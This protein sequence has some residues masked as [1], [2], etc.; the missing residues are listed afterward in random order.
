MIPI[1]NSNAI[2]KMR[3]VNAL[4]AQTQKLISQHIKVGITTK[5]LDA[6]AERFILEQG[7]KPNF[8]GYGNFPN[9]TCISVNDTVIHGVP[10]DYKLKDGDIVSVD[11]GAELDGFHGDMA[12]T[13]AVGQITEEARRLIEVTKE[14]FYKA[15]EQ[16]KEGS[17]V[18]D[19]SH[20]VQTHAE[21]HGYSVVKTYTGHG[22]GKKLHEDPSIPNFGNLSTG[23]KL[24]AGMTLAIEPMVNLGK[25]EVKVD[26]DGFSVK[27][28]DGKI[29]AHYENTVLVTKGE[30]EILSR[31]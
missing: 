12:R 13:Y 17:R 10:S 23:T 9:T 8:K 14:C 5:E 15:L 31:C 25:S 20:A 4:V 24:K 2:E 3:A 7:A 26:K 30:P 11:L 6:I 27:T 29:S 22:I 16:T 18:G 21:K 19:I 28:L 1:K